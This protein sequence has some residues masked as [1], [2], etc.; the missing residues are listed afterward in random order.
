[1][2]EMDDSVAAELQNYIAPS[3][4]NSRGEVVG[5]AEPSSEWSD[6]RVLDG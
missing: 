3:I 2:G 5:R 6:A 4:T 1:L